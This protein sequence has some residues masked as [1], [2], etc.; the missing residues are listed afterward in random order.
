MALKYLP[1]ITQPGINR[2]HEM[3]TCME[4]HGYNMTFGSCLIFP[5]SC[6]KEEKQWSIADMST[7]SG[8]HGS[9]FE[10]TAA[11]MSFGK[12]LNLHLPLCYLIGCERQCG[13]IAIST[14]V[15]WH[16]AVILPRACGLE[17]L[18]KVNTG[19]KIITMVKRL[20]MQ[21]LALAIQM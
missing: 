2:Q 1:K 20:K 16:T 5:N 4:H 6:F 17:T 3:L 7:D 10:S 9:R 21:N 19:V 11:L 18:L 15:K 12:T 14:L 8:S 13:E